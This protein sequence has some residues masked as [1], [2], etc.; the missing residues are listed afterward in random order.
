MLYN[1]SFGIRLCKQCYNYILWDEV[2]LI[3]SI[4]F[5]VVVFVLFFNIFK[6][7]LILVECNSDNLCKS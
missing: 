5:Y 2:G 6:W 1:R 7:L 3:K 4:S